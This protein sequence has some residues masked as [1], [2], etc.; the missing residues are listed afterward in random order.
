M[1]K[2]PMPRDHFRRLL[3]KLH[4][5]GVNIDFLR[6]M[7]DRQDGR[8]AV[9]GVAMTDGDGM[10]SVIIDKIDV[11]KGY[12]SDNIHLVCKCVKQMRG[13]NSIDQIVNFLEEFYDIRSVGVPYTIPIK[14]IPPGE[15]KQDT[16]CKQ[17]FNSNYN[18]MDPDEAKQY[19]TLCGLV[20]IDPDGTISDASTPDGDVWFLFDIEWFHPD[21]FI[22]DGNVYYR[23]DADSDDFGTKLMY[24]NHN[25]LTVTDQKYI[26]LLIDEYCNE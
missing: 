21:R 1:K 19:V 3:E 26:R 12:S 11:N 6:R 17:D 4:P 20:T 2:R 18:G 8:C 10:K 22:S 7:W 9:T 24:D 5:E 14:F 25:V 13:H 15:F 16:E 23:V